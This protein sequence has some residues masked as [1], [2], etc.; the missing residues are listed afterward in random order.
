MCILFLTP[1]LFDKDHPE[2]ASDI[3]RHK[4]DSVEKAKSGKGEWKPELA[5]QSEQA[6]SGDKHNMTMEQMQKMAA[7][8]GKEK[9]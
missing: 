7:E 5:S 8:K 3:D 2:R 9:K 4:S 1:K 6:L